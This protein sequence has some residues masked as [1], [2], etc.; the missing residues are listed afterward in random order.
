MVLFRGVEAWT[1]A[2]ANID[3]IS[4]DSVWIKIYKVTQITHYNIKKHVN[5]QH[6]YR[7]LPIDQ[8][9]LQGR[10]ALQCIMHLIFN[11]LNVV[12]RCEDEHKK[13]NTISKQRKRFKYIY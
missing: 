11:I 6:V 2:E 5:L 4:S 12:Q 10:L 13:K 1:E 3:A 9:V 8:I 7:K